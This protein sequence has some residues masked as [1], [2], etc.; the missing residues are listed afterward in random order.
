M[1]KKRK[2]SN[3]HGVKYVFDILSTDDTVMKLLKLYGDDK[4]TSG[5]KSWSKLTA[6]LPKVY[7]KYL[8]VGFINKS[9]YIHGIKIGDIVNI[10]YIPN[11]Q[12]YVDYYKQHNISNGL[13]VFVDVANNDAI[14]ATKSTGG[15]IKF[16]SLLREGCH[17]L[18]ISN[19]Y[20]YIIDKV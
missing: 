2:Q 15:I 13:V 11:S 5:E 3:M 20:S 6:I 10:S 19:G 1:S 4:T 8:W 17:Y 7:K 16:K 12:K 9:E 14:I 18:G